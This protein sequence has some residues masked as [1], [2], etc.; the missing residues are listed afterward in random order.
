MHPA[1]HGGRSSPVVESVAAS[2]LLPSE[3]SVVLVVAAPVLSLVVASV[4]VS[5]DV[6]VL[7]DVV[8][9]SLV[10]VLAVV[11]DVVVS[12]ALVLVV[13]SVSLLDDVPHATTIASDAHVAAR[14]NARTGSTNEV[15]LVLYRHSMAR[16]RRETRW[17]AIALLAVACGDAASSDEGGEAA[18]DTASTSAPTSAPETSVD[19]SNATSI[20]ATDDAASSSTT[21]GEPAWEVVL[22]ADES[23]G[24]LFSVWGPSREHVYVVGGQQGEGG[25]SQGAM[26]VRSGGAWAPAALPEATPKLNW[27]HGTADLRVTVGEGGAVLVREGDDADAP[28]TMQSCATVLPL[29]GA[30]AIAPDD[31]WVVGGDGF[32][33]PPVLCHF[34]GAAWARVDLP[35][36][37]VDAKALFKVFALAS[38][39]VWAVGDVGLVLHF[40]G[41]A[42]SQV[43]IDT[44]ADIIS[45]WGIGP[46]ELLAVGG[47]SNGVLARY[48]GAAWTVATLDSPGLNGVWMDGTGHAH[49]VGIMG[50][51]LSVGAGGLD[52]EPVPPPT[53]LT[54]HAVWSPGDD[55]FIAVGGNLEQPPPFVGVI[56]E[57]N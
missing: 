6:V 25:V 27:I 53:L 3:L 26:L 9:S 16:A 47:R 36:I 21:A 31:V 17:W 38:D 54:L 29:W 39:D 22:E 23:I 12:A 49:G 30:W 42:W 20:T 55:T 41:S 57:R 52:A 37:D 11:V 35:E 5:F 46:A 45:L 19:T 32:D 4:V 44:P 7:V 33:R 15:M 14:R 10:V 1:S 48:D 40:D 51:V 13:A 43:A 50:S 24:A 34:D 28:W 18:A 2:S 8:V 56:V